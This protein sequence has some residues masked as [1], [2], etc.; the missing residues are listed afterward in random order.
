[1]STTGGGRI[2]SLAA[3]SR[4]LGQFPQRDTAEGTTLDATAVAPGLSAHYGRKR[5]SREKGLLAASEAQK[6]R[7]MVDPD[8]PEGARD[9]DDDEN[10]Q[11]I[12]FTSARQSDNAPQGP[13]HCLCS[14]T[15]APVNSST[16][17][18]HFVAPCHRGQLNL[19]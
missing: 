6:K 11:V 8:A 1:M 17:Q 18:H 12:V 7:D 9:A 13:G 14:R 15:S 2:E 16:L 19:T 10:N 3:E 4:K 5:V